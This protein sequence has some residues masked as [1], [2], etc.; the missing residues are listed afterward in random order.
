MLIPKYVNYKC[1]SKVSRQEELAVGKIRSK[2]SPPIG[3]M[4]SF[5]PFFVLSSDFI[6]GEKTGLKAC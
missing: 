6:S 1:L 2:F 4:I 5:L 3:K